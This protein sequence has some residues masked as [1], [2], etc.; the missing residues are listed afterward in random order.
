M[1]FGIYTQCLTLFVTIGVHLQV[2]DFN[3]AVIIDVDT[4]CFQIEEDNGVF[5]IQFHLFAMI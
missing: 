2:A 1:H 5:Q 3:D 4:R